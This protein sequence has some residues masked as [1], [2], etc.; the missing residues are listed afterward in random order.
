MV[1]KDYIPNSCVKAIDNT[2]A[3]TLDCREGVL[4]DNYIA[5]D[6]RGQ[7]FVAIVTYETA[8]SSGYTLYTGTTE[9]LWEVWQNFADE[10]DEE[11]YREL[12]EE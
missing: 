6:K 7:L 5:V 12:D 3:E 4:L 2:V 10:Y 1:R 8:W 11:Y 9:E